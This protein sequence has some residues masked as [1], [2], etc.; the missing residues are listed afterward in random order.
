MDGCC[1][2]NPRSKGGREVGVGF[3]L[4]KKKKIRKLFFLAEVMAVF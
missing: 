1:L 3:Y 4:K 2:V